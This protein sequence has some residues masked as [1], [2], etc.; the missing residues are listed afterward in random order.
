[1]PYKPKVNCTTKGCSNYANAGDGGLCDVHKKQRHRDYSKTRDDAEHT[2]IYKTKAWKLARK[3]ALY[4]D[5]GWCV[6]CKE[7]PAVLV[8]HIKEV[9]DGGA[10]YALDNLQSLC[11]KCHAKKTKE[12]A[13]LRKS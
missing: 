6:I 4:R 12:V 5:E 1:M 9:K 11:A 3:Q 13:K 8:D 10:L 7:V 2:K